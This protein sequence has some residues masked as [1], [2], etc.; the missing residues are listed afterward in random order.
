MNEMQSLPFFH[1][2][3]LAHPAL[4]QAELC[5]CLTRPVF[6]GA[7]FPIA[8]VHGLP[9]CAAPGRRGSP[10][11]LFQIYRVHRRLPVVPAALYVLWHLVPAAARCAARS[12]AS[13]FP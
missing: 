11:V 8:P 7:P 2:I 6:V 3:F 10:G 13:A 9:L 4:R 1:P 12:A 5:S